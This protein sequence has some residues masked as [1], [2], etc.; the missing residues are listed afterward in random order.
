MTYTLKDF[1]RCINHWLPQTKEYIWS[2]IIYIAFLTQYDIFRKWILKKATKYIHNGEPI[3]KTTFHIDYSDVIESEDISD[4][5]YKD[6]TGEYS[7]P[8]QIEKRIK[9][10]INKYASY[11]NWQ[12]SLKI[13]RMLGL[14]VEKWRDYAGMNIDE[15]LYTEGYRLRHREI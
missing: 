5:V 14:T 8:P 12:I 2:R 15:Y 6:F 9:T 4:I 13:R 10:I 11:K 7:I 3:A 1:V